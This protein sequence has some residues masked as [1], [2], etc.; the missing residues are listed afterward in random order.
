MLLGY[1]AGA[2]VSSPPDE[3]RVLKARRVCMRTVREG[4]RQR[5]KMGEQTVTVSTLL[6]KATLLG[7]LTLLTVMMWAGPASATENGLIYY[8]SNG[9]IGS[10][11]PTASNAGYNPVSQFN[12]VSDF[13]ISRDGQTLVYNQCGMIAGCSAA[14]STVPLSDAEYRGSEVWITNL[15]SSATEIRSPQFSPD[16]Q[17]IYFAG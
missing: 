10:V 14:L 17:T 4:N 8:I 1:G 15:S 13:D 12:G 11:D 16:G 7:I 6:K 3:G 9:Y 2:C 5:A